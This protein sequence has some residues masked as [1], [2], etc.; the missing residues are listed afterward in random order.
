MDLVEQEKQQKQQDSHDSN[1]DKRQHGNV[2]EPAI[3]ERKIICGQIKSQGKSTAIAYIQSIPSHNHFESHP[4]SSYLLRKEHSV[5]W[6][7][8]ELHDYEPN[9]NCQTRMWRMKCID[10]THQQE[11]INKRPVSTCF[12]LFISRAFLLPSISCASLSH[13]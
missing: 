7:I 9:E 12:F 10:I 13:F 8:T 4:L 1:N 11:L 6:T 5:Q 3:E 2:T